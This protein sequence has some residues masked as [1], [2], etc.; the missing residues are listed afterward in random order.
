M[1]DINILNKLNAE[2]AKVRLENLRIIVQNTSFPKVT[3]VYINNHIHTTFSFSPY[4]PTAAVY[5]ARAEGLSTAGIVDHDSIAGAREFIEAGK[6]V[7]MPITVGMECRVKM[8]GTT[9]IDKRTNNPDQLGVSYMT[10]QG[11][12]H[13]NIDKLDSFFAPLR[14]KRN[15]RNRKMI[16]NING[17]LSSYGIM[18]DFEKDVIPL[19]QYKYGGSVTERH[20][21]L[22]LAKK[23]ISMDKPVYETLDSIGVSLTDKQKS[24]LSDTSD[25]FFE[26][27]VL[28]ILKSAFVK[29]IFIP[30]T[31]ECP[32][33]SEVVSLAN[34][35]GA[36]LCYAYLGDVTDS[37]TGD[38]A[39][40]KFEDDYLDE[41]FSE[42]SKAGVGA[43]TYMPTRNT[44]EQLNR[45]RSLCDD[46]KMMQVSGEDINSPTQ[47]FVI[48]AMENPMFANLVDSTWS[49]IKN[50]NSSID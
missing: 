16:S 25:P 47:S 21:M 32:E 18:L 3:P 28:G 26:Y 37:V 29:K 43:I 49:L 30:A 15:E 13:K 38:K 44:L 48:K 34:D 6:I 20:L 36:I 40:Q 24:K 9:L 45:V 22:A 7:G 23:L 2:D 46:Y 33:L 10:F 8:T 31:D 42:L 50:E 5:A 17:I 1:I 19:S 12:P 41:L 27:T 4:S 39:A 35:V 14:E 11:V